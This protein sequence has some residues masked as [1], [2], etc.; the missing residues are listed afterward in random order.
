MSKVYPFFALTP[1]AQLAKQVI[2]PPYDV[3][4][5]EEAK[6]IAQHSPQ[7]FI[8]VTRSEIDLPDAVDPHSIEAYEQAKKQRCATQGFLSSL[9]FQG[10]TQ[11][12]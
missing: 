10:A 5:R 11:E 12:F 4:S 9:K 7:S 8:R 6:I 1:A 2:A 3:L